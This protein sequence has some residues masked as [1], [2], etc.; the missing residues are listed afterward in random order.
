M[1]ACS[2]GHCPRT[3]P[4]GHR[5]CQLHADE[6]RGW[7]AE[8]PRQARLLEEFLAPAGRTT[9][10]RLG[11]TGRAHAP[12]PVDLRVLVLLGPGH[13]DALGSDDDGTVP[14]LTLLGAWA[15]FIAY[16]YP[17][18]RTDP[19]GTQHTFPC[20]QAVPRRGGAT[21]TGWCN[22][23]TAYLPYALTH[24]WAGELHRQL[25][26]LIHRIRDLTHAIPHEHPMTAPCPACNR[27]GL[28]RIDGQDGVTCQA[29]GRHLAFDA[30]D[31]HA[32]RTLEAHRAASADGT[33]A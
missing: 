11:G 7:L 25:G 28:V 20:E 1:S 4:D 14:I 31:A 3:A 29:C 33:A 26:D 32:A 6:L 22:W 24:P 17:A 13:A 8:L 23:L 18:A 10:G 9:Q 30:Y 27:F 21:I 16:S 19:Y 2:I 5:A 15:G 12:L